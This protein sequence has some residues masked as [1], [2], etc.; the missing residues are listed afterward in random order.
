MDLV[1]IPDHTSSVPTR[2]NSYPPRRIYL[3][4]LCLEVG[5]LGVRFSSMMCLTVER[6]L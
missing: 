4:T 5:F 2:R 6:G 3:L 1:Q